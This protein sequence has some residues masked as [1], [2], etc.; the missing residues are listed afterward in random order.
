[1]RKQFCAYTRGSAGGAAV[2]NRLVH[3]E[4]IDE[5]RE[6]LSGLVNWEVIHKV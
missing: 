6:I 3:A 2:R 1:M 4:T 5:Y